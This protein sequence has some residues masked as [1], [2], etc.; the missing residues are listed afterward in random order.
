MPVQVNRLGR[1]DLVVPGWARIHGDWEAGMDRHLV[2]HQGPAFPGFDHSCLPDRDPFGHGGDGAS[3][4]RAFG[5][6]GGGERAPF[7][8]TLSEN[9]AFPRN[10]GGVDATY[11]LDGSPPEPRVLRDGFHGPS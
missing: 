10:G 3:R 9:R 1:R 4:K 8:I 2:T 6:V 7:H 11:P 5:P